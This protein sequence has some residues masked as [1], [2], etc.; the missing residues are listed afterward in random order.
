M[1]LT[2]K[3][4]EKYKLMVDEHFVN[5]F[6]GAAAYMKFSKTTNINTS[7]TNFVRICQHEEIAEYIKEKQQEAQAII[8]LNNI[9]ILEEL[10]SWLEMDITD[11]IGLTIDEVKELPIVFKRHIK[12]VRHEKKTTINVDGSSFETENVYVEIYDKTKAYEMVNK[13]I[14][15][16][17]VDNKQKSEID[18]VG[19][20]TD[21]LRARLALLKQLKA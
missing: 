1:A 16:Y 8:N 6:N 14:G 7:A 4:I 9:G 12:K 15:F 3:S 13:H 2:K 10:K 5:G 17:S 21:E 19:E 20:T 11:A 18:L